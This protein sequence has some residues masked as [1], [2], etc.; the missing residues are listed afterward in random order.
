MMCVSKARHLQY[1]LKQTLEMLVVNIFYEYYK[2]WPYC[3]TE[4]WFPPQSFCGFGFGSGLPGAPSGPG[5]VQTPASSQPL[6]AAHVC[7]PSLFPV[8]CFIPLAQCLGIL[9]C[10]TCHLT[11]T[12]Y[13][14]VHLCCFQTLLEAVSVATACKSFLKESVSYCPLSLLADCPDCWGFLSTVT[15]Y[16]YSTVLQALFLTCAV[17]AGLTAYTFQSKRDFSKMGAGCVCHGCCSLLM[18]SSF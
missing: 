16:E 3:L 7:K 17:F 8:C 12:I 10:K 5:H 11:L 18:P 9:H 13:L 14:H 2:C 1:P 15:F 6:P 4:V